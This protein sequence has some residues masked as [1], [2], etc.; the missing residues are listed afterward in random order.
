MNHQKS[1]SD[2]KMEL[3]NMKKLSRSTRGIEAWV[4]G[5]MASVL[6]CVSALGQYMTTQSAGI[7]INDNAP[8]SPYPS[9][10]DLTKSNVVGS[11]EKVTV[12]LN[13]VKH[14]YANDVG[15]LLVAPDGS[16]V[17]LMRNA[18]GG[19]PINGAN[20][21]FDDS[22]SALSQFAAVGSG[23][24][25]LG[26]FDPTAN[27]LGAAPAGPYGASLGGLAA[28][29]P[30]GKWSLYVEDNSPLNAGTIDAWTLNLYTT[31]VLTLAT[32]YVNLDENGTPASLS[33]TLQDSSVP[34][35][36]TVSFGGAATN[37]FVSAAGSVSGLNGTV[38]LTPKLN[39]FGTN[40]LI[41]FVSDG[42]AS[43]QSDVTVAIKHLNQPPTIT[44]TNVSVATVAGTVSPVINAVVADVD[45]DNAPSSL[46]V[47]VSSSNTNLINPAGV[48]FD[49]ANTGGLRT[50]T[51]VPVGTATGTAT[52][53]FTVKDV[54]NLTGAA[55][56]AVTVNP[57]ANPVFAST[58]LLGLSAAGTTNSSIAVSNV[59]GAIGNVSLAVSGLKTVAGDNLSLA[60]STSGRFADYPSTKRGQFR[61]EHV[62]PAKLFQPLQAVHRC[63]PWTQSLLFRCRSPISPPWWVLPLMVHGPYGPPTAERLVRSA[64]AGF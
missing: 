28:S 55:T 8:G 6:M 45:P 26:D 53:I 57:A 4:L 32:N 60:L 31:P 33:F 56:L 13:N 62:C 3:L 44:I 51:I 25:A 61:A 22:G 50:F 9:V 21:T 43:A 64:A 15:V 52:L 59:S 46:S 16:K 35:G 12:T 19:Q 49:P 30:N 7:V 20:I 29:T 40:T 23:T 42:L 14:G 27:F 36:Y 38:T 48:F 11:I 2:S 37:N 54:G 1:D 5:G 24:F 47:T 41:V 18:G 17:V 39:A 63:P 34:P 58:N 10:I